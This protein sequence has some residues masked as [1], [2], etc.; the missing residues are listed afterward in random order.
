MIIKTKNSQREFVLKTECCITICIT[1]L[2]RPATVFSSSEYQNGSGNRI[3]YGKQLQEVTSLQ[4]GDTTENLSRSNSAEVF[5]YWETCAF[6]S[7]KVRNSYE[8][9]T[10][11]RDGFCLFYSPYTRRIVI[12]LSY[13]CGYA[14]Y[15]SKIPRAVQPTP[16]VA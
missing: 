1:I 13:C 8:L 14:L 16:D 4:A 15:E 7:N 12:V 3:C 9:R 6:K 11:V 2:K 10:F 5:S